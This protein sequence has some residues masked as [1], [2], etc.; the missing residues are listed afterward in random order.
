MAVVLAA[1]FDRALRRL[2][3]GEVSGGI[4]PLVDAATTDAIVV[5]PATQ[6]H[7]RNF[8]KLLLRVH[9]PGVIRSRD[10]MDRLASVR[11]ARIWEVLAR[12]TPDDFDILPGH[13]E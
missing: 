1:E 6:V 7:R 8:Q 11:R 4:R 13:V 12:V 3:E 10:R 5:G 2:G 9:R